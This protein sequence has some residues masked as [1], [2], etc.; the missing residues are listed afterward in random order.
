MLLKTTI[1]VRNDEYLD[2]LPDTELDGRVEMTISDQGSWNAALMMAQGNRPDEGSC[3]GLLV[4]AVAATED[5]EHGVEEEIGPDHTSED[6]DEQELRR[7]NHHGNSRSGDGGDG[8]EGASQPTGLPRQGRSTGGGGATEAGDNSRDGGSGQGQDAGGNG[9]GGD[10]GDNDD[11]ND[12][13]GG[14][15]DLYSRPSK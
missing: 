12:G 4:V 9:G 2:L 14:D 1:T 13:D 10:G 6:E 3:A 8:G 5:S 11:G 7:G 15:D